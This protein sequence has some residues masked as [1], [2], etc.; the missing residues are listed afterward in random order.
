MKKA[1]FLPLLLIAVLL[2]TSC[3]KEVGPK[4]V[5]AAEKAVSSIKPE[6]LQSVKGAVHQL[7]FVL[8]DL[9]SWGHSRRFTENTEWYS[10]ETAWKIVNEYLTEQKIA[11]RARE[12]AKTVESETLKQDLES[13][14]NSLEQ[15]YE[16]RDVNLLIHAHR[17][18]HDLDYWVFGNETFY[19]KGS[20]PPRGSRDYWGV[21]VT[22]EGKK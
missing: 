14:A 10:S 12:I 11:D 20:E 3:G 8:N 13:F 17:I 15:A 6:D 9:V 18:I 22:L 7:H 2:L 4:N 16:K 19:D 5:D 21:T 1:K